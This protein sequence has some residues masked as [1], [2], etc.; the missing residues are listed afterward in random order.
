MQ[1]VLTFYPREYSMHGLRGQ[2]GLAVDDFCVKLPQKLR[3]PLRDT[4]R[5][6]SRGRFHVHTEQEKD[7]EEGEGVYLGEIH[8]VLC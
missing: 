8:C 4:R 7:D 1:K 5:W 2:S 6:S 3:R